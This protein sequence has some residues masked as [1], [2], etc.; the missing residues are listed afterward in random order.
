M[1][2]KRGQVRFEGSQG[3]GDDD[4]V[5]CDSKRLIVNELPAPPPDG[6]TLAKYKER[7][8]LRPSLQMTPAIKFRARRDRRPQECR[9]TDAEREFG[10]GGGRILLPATCWDLGG[11]DRY[12]AAQQDR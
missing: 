6:V 2:P 7:V 1:H 9:Q 10:F 11:R 4:D 3:K 5:D 8:V 12:A